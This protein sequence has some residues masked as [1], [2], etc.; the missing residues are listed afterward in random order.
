VVLESG[1][2]EMYSV[3]QG[4]LGVPVELALTGLP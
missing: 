3:L 4:F 2:V 1:F